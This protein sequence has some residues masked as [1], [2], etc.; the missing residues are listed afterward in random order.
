VR[1]RLSHSALGSSLSMVVT[2]R[3][4]TDW[5]KLV[6]VLLLLRMAVPSHLLGQSQAIQTPQQTNQKIEQLAS[7][8][9]ASNTDP[10]LGAGDLL[11]IDVFDVPELSRD[12]RVTDSG[13]I[14]FPLVPERIPV[15]G[16]TP[17]EVEGKLEQILAAD[18][19][20]AHPQVSV[21]VKEQSSQAVSVVGAVAR[22]LV[23]QIMK[24]TTLIEILAAAGG[25]TDEA[26]GTIIVTRSRGSTDHLEAVSDKADTPPDQQTNSITIQLKDLLES[27]R[28]EYNIFIQGGDIV[29]VPRA[30]II[31]VLGFGVAQQGEYVLQSH[32]DQITALKAVAL[33]H[34]LTTFSKADSAVIM[35][36]DPVTGNRMQIPVHLKQIQNHKADDVRMQTNDI[37]FVPDSRGKKA[38]ARGTEAALGIGTQVAVYRVAY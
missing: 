27:G 4:V 38:L 17:F 35:R 23:M 25:I 14:S 30:G 16:L 32:G 5:L 28:P 13:V 34:G 2:V 12:V 24:P 33:A 36:N 6:C 37:L 20:V 29:T 22:P 19:L 1:I 26:G 7:L 8:A 31:Y 3:G 21:F 15:A 18:G 11:H 10:P 9:R